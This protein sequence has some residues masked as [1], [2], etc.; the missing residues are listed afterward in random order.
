MTKSATLREFKPNELIFDAEEARAIL[1]FIFKS[2]TSIVSA[3]TIDDQ[4]RS[5][6]QA[7]LLEAIDASYALG[8]IQALVGSIAAPSPSVQKLIRKFAQKAIKHWF[9]HATTSDLLKV[10]IY[11]MVRSDLE[12]SFGRVLQMYSV[13]AGRFNYKT[14]AVAYRPAITQHLARA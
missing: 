6:A 11:E 7:L 10:K 4:L 9:K 13:T 1:G 14:T 2:K 8:F 12:W 5:F 3:L